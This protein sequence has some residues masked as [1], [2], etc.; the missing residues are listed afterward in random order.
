MT[1]AAVKLITLLLPEC[2]AY[3]QWWLPVWKLSYRSGTAAARRAVR[4]NHDIAQC[5]L[6]VRKVKFE[7]A[8]SNWMTLKVTQGQRNRRY[9]P[10]S[11]N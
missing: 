2:I 1:V 5:C 6:A 4:W 10:L 3:L 7:K 11:A 8:C 9:L